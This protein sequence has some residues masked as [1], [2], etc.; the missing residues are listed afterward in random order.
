M[1]G[2]MEKALLHQFS[3]DPALQTSE[4]SIV[5]GGAATLNSPQW[6]QAAGFAT[7]PYR[8]CLNDAAL[9]TLP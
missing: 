3:A 7:L 6:F 9:T 4:R 5:A 1:I 2:K 8:R